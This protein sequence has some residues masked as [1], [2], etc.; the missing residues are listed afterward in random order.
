M[1]VFLAVRR[2]AGLPSLTTQTLSPEPGKQNTSQQDSAVSLLSAQDWEVEAGALTAQGHAWVPKA[3]A[4]WG[5]MGHR[6]EQ[7]SATSGLRR[8]RPHSSLQFPLGYTV[9]RFTKL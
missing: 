8:L 5:Y 9:S 6:T 1:P 4:N 3:Q 7:S 2:T